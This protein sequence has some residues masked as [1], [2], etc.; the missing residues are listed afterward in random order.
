[1][2]PYYADDSVT[3]Y[4]GD[5]R[6]WMPDADV[7]VTDPPY[8]LDHRSGFDSSWSGSAIANDDTVDAR[9]AVLAM[10]GKR[11]ADMLG[12][13]TPRITAELYRHKSATLQRDASDAMQRVVGA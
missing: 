3:I 1:M 10:W 4:H 5:S 13:A 12:H 11:P 2:T 9:D 7:M 8:G 6:E